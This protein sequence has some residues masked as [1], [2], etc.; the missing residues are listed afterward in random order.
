MSDIIGQMSLDSISD[1]I[2][3]P[4]KCDWVSRP[5]C[6]R[7]HVFLSRYDVDDSGNAFNLTEVAC[8]HCGQVNRLD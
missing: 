7:C 3:P 5:V 1:D 6:G 4:I 8:A 2:K